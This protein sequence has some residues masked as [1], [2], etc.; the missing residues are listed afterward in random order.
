MMFF[1]LFGDVF[2]M[3]VD[4]HV[5]SML[6]SFFMFFA[7]LSGIDFTWI[8]HHLLK[9]VYVFVDTCGI[10]NNVFSKPTFYRFLGVFVDALWHLKM[11]L[12]DSTR[13]SKSNKTS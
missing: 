12:L 9:D 4:F 7:L 1:A 8:C 10:K 5:G 2:L 6:V 3:N 13:H 11:Q